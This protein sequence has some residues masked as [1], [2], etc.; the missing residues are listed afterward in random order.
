MQALLDAYTIVREIGQL[1]GVKVRSIAPTQCLCLSYPWVCHRLRSL[2]LDAR[3][4]LWSAISQMA[5]QFARLH[6]YFPTLGM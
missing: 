6:S 3:R 1:D 2:S 5:G 4:L